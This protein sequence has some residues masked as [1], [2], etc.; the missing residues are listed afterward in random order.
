MTAELY[1][2][3]RQQLEERRSAV[4]ERLDISEDELRQRAAGYVLTP[5]EREALI[6]LEEIDFLLGGEG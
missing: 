3:T 6:E 4:L 5:E 1:E 2:V